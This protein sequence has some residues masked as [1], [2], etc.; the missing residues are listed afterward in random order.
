MLKQAISQA[1][2]RAWHNPWLLLTL[3]VTFWG[4]NVVAARLAT[5]E[6]SPFLLGGARWLVA[7]AI[8]VPLFWRQLVREREIIRQHWL[9]L[10][11]MSVAGYTAYSSLFYA[12]GTL[13]AG[14]NISMLVAIAP[15]FAFVLGWVFLR[16]AA[17][18]IVSLAL[19]LTLTGALSVA[20][21]G[22]LSVLRHLSFNA[23]DIMVIC[24][25][26]L[27]GGYTVFLR[28]RP[29]LSSITFFTV[30]CII[31][32]IT[33]LPIITWEI[34]AG[35]V[36][37]PGW[38]GWLLLLYAGIFP[39]ILS[40]FFYMRGVELIG[41]QRTSLFYNLT[42]IFGAIFSV[43]LLGEPFALYHAAG[44]ALVMSGIALAERGRA[45]Q[46]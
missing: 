33:S 23:G 2:N 37:W 9:Y 12:A 11:L 40:M 1:L 24:A 26:I 38:K 18:P 6:I 42:P 46:P 36:I 44:F 16:M 30:L 22:D 20:S 13:T 7:C 4:S 35:K 39:T 29:A 21:R 3:C 10:L 14:V 8:L 45:R 25:S 28:K 41:P 17:G 43:T 27:H 34:A 5:G 32:L 15:I 31:A 19:C